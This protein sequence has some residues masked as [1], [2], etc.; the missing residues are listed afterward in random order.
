MNN[1]G[2]ILSRFGRGIPPRID[3]NHTMLVFG[4]E[5]YTYR[6]MN[7]K[8]NRLAYSL[9]E[10]GWNKG[11][12]VGIMLK[13][14]TEWVVSYFALA[15][16]G[17]V[18]VPVNYMLK[19]PEVE[20]IIKNSE[21][22]H[23]I[24]GN[25]LVSLSNKIRPQLKAVRDCVVVGGKSRGFHDYE[26]LEKKGRPIEPQI[27][28]DMDDDFTIQYTSGTTGT[29]KGAIHTHGGTIWDFIP[30]VGDLRVTSQDIWV[31][32]A[33]LCWVA[34]FDH[35]TLATW[36]MG[37]TVVLL[38]STG[39]KIENLLGLIE[40]E[41]ATSAYIAPAI[42]K[43]ILDFPDTRKYS[44]DSLI[45]VT[46][47]AT[48]IPI[49]VIREFMDLFQK[50]S[51][52]Q[53]YGLSEHP[54]IAVSLSSEY[55][56]TKIC[57]I[58]KPLTSYLV[59]LVDEND[60]EVEPGVEGEI[61]IKSPAVMRGYWKKPEETATTLKDGWLHTGDLA[62]QD[63]DGF[64]YIAGRKKDML[65]SGGLNIYP[66]EVE[67]AVLSHP[68]VAEVAVIGIP[69]KEWGE[70]GKA[71]VVIR[72][73]ETPT[74]EELIAFCKEKLANYKVPKEFYFTIEPLPRTLSGK[75]KKFEL[76]SDVKG[77]FGEE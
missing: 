47:G 10:L 3:S 61:Y 74:Q 11:E 44:I 37:G 67:E 71:I 50:V 62:R 55:A 70:V 53:C 45:K 19:A 65:I 66:A 32:I 23:M 22:K 57:S 6:Q 26:S 41:K 31:C 68:S 1:V 64:P 27:A 14:C 48:P 16:L 52:Y 25:D 28:V 24:V 7:E 39:L 9:A 35:M 15:K 8:V 42:L 4:D 13:N 73:E 20:F 5:R 46:S 18:V 77:C 56:L 21:C 29:Q 38:P 51:F 60:R 40:K 34:G 58:G 49:D 54:T 59:K 30:Q 43:R 76:R 36:L 69:D 72:P 33:A 75:V 17:L 63:G 2:N 12:K